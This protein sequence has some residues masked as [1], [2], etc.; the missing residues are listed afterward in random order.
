M[1]KLIAKSALRG[2]LL[3][4]FGLC[5]A[6]ALSGQVAIAQSGQWHIS[7][8]GTEKW[9]FLNTSSIGISSVHIADFNGDGRDDVFRGNGSNW[10]ISYGGMSGWT[11][12]NGSSYTVSNLRFGDF[13]GDGRTDVFRSSG[14]K[15]YVS[16]SATSQWT[17]VN[18]SN[19]GVRDIRVGDF[20]GD[21]RDD[22]F[23]ANGS[24]WRVSY[25]ATGGWRQINRS[26]IRTRDLRVS[27]FNGDGRADVFRANGQDWYISY[28]GNTRWT[29]V[30]GSNVTLG[31]LRFAD[32]NGDGR[33][34]VFRGNGSSW[35]VSYSATGS[36]QWLNGSSTTAANVKLGDFY[37]D[38][39]AD[40][41]FP[42]SATLFKPSIKRH[43]N[44]SFTNAQADQMLRGAEDVVKK[45]DHSTDDTA[46]PVEFA[47][48]GGVGSFSVGNGNV[49]NF[50]RLTLV[51]AAPGD[52]KVVNAVDYCD[53]F[54]TGTVGCA[55]Y[56][57][58]NQVIERAL[59]IS[60][61]GGKLHAHERGHNSGLDHTSRN[62][63][64]MRQGYD[65]NKNRMTS[66]YCSD[67][68]D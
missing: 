7:D 9:Q 36:W 49:T 45:R 33:T 29:R 65:H 12:V 68:K 44:V 39:R 5:S 16:Y 57:T 54:S 66:G 46:C 41:F 40:V 6:V 59:A 34:D 51:Y 61:N 17:Q 1:K 56:Y 18:R 25:G 63:H 47:R 15:W 14:G 67:Y 31:S 11:R 58:D 28:S 8:N 22:I 4:F 60:G 37:G 52:V 55:L 21:G 13:N 20:N 23:Y 19:I 62:H 35:Y 27:D 2:R 53:G 3:R 43:R 48:D 30:N 24:I 38:G 64:I 42:R 10:Y 50:W 26:S 32:F